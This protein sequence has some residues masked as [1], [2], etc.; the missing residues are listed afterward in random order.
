MVVPKAGEVLLFPS[1]INHMIENNGSKHPRRA[2]AFNSF[3]KGK[4]GNYRDV[5]ELT[6]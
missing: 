5:S 2:I 4:I 3:V 6:V 1:E